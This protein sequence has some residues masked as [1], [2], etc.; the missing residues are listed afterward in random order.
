MAVDRTLEL[1]LSDR[2]EGSEAQFVIGVMDCC[3]VE[4]ESGEPPTMWHLC[5][6]AAVGRVLFVDPALYRRG[7]EGSVLRHRRIFLARVAN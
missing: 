3:I 4:E 2:Y 7:I 5:W 1:L 6:Q